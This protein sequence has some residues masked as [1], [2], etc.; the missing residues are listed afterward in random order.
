[1]SA[2]ATV[3][4]TLSV[5]SGFSKKSQAPSLVASTAVASVAL[6]DIIITGSSGLSSR[7]A[8]S[9]ASP[10]ISGMATSS[11]T[12]SNARARA[13]SSAMR[14]EPATSTT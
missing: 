10:S 5:V 6:P 3:M 9:V 14:P 8:L 4:S 1:M 12:A 2:L 7:S 13:L 11:S